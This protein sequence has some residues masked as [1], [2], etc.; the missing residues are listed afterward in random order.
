MLRPC[1][2][3]CDARRRNVAGQSLHL[4]RP[5]ETR[6]VD[7]PLGLRDFSWQQF[8][9]QTWR[10]RERERKVA[11][12][13]MERRVGGSR[14]HSRR[15]ARLARCR[16]RAS[17]CGAVG[18]SLSTRRCFQNVSLRTKE[19]SERRGEF[20]QRHFLVRKEESSRCSYLRIR[21]GTTAGD[22]CSKVSRRGS[23]L[24]SSKR[25]LSTMP[26]SHHS[27][28]SPSTILCLELINLR[29]YPDSGS[30]C[31]HAKGTLEEVVLEAI[32]QGFTTF[33]LSEHAP[34]SAERGST[35]PLIHRIETP[36]RYRQEDLYPE[37]VRTFVSR[38]HSR[39]HSP[40]RF[41]HPSRT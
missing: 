35:V 6:A 41:R 14:W 23:P 11:R 24:P 20:K 19:N 36:L 1:W 15:L 32:S 16:P 22:D 40:R 29:P 4:L 5:P 18:P 10:G 34:R 30:F 8:Q 17:E 21:G 33:G 25:P 38:A 3:T 12:G 27:R 9:T 31:R 2:R 37:E 13:L 39:P 26:H 28:E 7:A